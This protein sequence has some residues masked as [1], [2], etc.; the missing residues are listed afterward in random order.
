MQ[1]VV[2]SCEVPAEIE[3]VLAAAAM[4]ELSG[5]EEVDGGSLRLWPASAGDVDQLRERLGKWPTRVESVADGQDWNEDW[6]RREW[7]AIE[8]GQRFFL[9]P[10]WDAE[11]ATPSGRIRLAMHPGT[12]FGNGD[13][14][15]THL[16]LMAMEQDLRAGDVFLDVGCGSGLLG[17]AADALG[18]GQVFGCD[19]APGLGSF[20][21]SVDAVRGGSCDYVAANIQ[22][23]VLTAILGQIRRVMKPG[24]RGVLSGVLPEQVEELTGAAG[25]SGL[26]VKGR[27]ELGGWAAVRVAANPSSVSGRARWNP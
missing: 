11:S 2:V 7:R 16:C 8:V 18:A 1:C 15:A 24:G 10:P 20:T 21:G 25:R 19:L 12:A 9:A 14:P 17:Q 5:V 23:G 26:A 27:A 13:H 22:L 4:I 3:A 6:Q